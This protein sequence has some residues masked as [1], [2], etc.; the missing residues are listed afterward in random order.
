MHEY[1]REFIRFALDRN[2]LRFGEFTLK[3]DDDGVQTSRSQ[4]TG[5]QEYRGAL[6]VAGLNA[7][8][9]DYS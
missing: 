4:E 9:P 5:A 7:H 2:V 8:I 6:F 1:Q 3:S